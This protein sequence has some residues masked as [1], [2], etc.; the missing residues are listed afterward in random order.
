MAIAT[1]EA[2]DSLAF[3][4]CSRDADRTWIHVP[5]DRPPLHH[6]PADRDHRTVAIRGGEGK[7]MALTLSPIAALLLPVLRFYFRVD[8]KK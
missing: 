8:V 7:D 4:K 5:R 2:S 1:R 3:L 6:V